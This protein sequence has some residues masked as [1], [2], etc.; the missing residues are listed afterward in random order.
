[1][2]IGRIPSVEGGIQPTIVDAKGDLIV[3]TAADTVS[4]LAVG[5][6]NQ[7]LTVDSS[8]STGLKWAT[9]ASGGLVYITSQTFTSASAVNVNNCF[10]SSYRNYRILFE[11][12]GS[13]NTAVRLRMRAS[14]T[15]ATGSDYFYQ[16]LDASNTTLTAERFSSQAQ[17]QIS[18]ISSTVVTF[19][20]FDFYRPQIASPTGWYAS[21]AYMASSSS[22]IRYD[23]AGGHNL[24]TSYDG[25]SIYPATGTFDGVVRV[26]AYANS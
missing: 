2:T 10:T 13:A 26:Y 4:R 23:Y 20:S 22:L 1:M 18:G 7:V 25:F 3:A 15:D 5:S 21:G 19:G 12:T 14:G 6:A 11:Y 9:P 24:S 17:G 8:T 16:F